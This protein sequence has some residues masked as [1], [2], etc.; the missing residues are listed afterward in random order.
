MLRHA[1]F[2]VAACAAATCFAMPAQ[3]Q[4]YRLGQI[5]MVGYGFCP[6][7]TVMA[8]GRMLQISAFPALFSLYR[9][10]YGGDGVT[11]FAL[12]DLQNRAPVSVGQGN[13]LSNYGPGQ[14]AGGVS[15]QLTGANMP[16]HSHV[17]YLQAS[18]SAPSVDNPGG[19]SLATFSGTAVQLYYKGTAAPGVKMKSGAQLAVAG[20]P[21]G[22]GAP[23]NIRTPY[24]TLLY[25]VVMNGPM[26][27]P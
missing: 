10:S 20:N 3:A 25:C 6:V 21:G 9:T 14:T 18:S 22:V 27:T 12:P 23:V 7:G 26:G 5:I 11:T 1:L 16:V 15:V 24:L 4:A 17:A 2:G 19:A 8:D 13:G